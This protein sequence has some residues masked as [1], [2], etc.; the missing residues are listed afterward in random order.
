[1]S[2]QPKHPA[3]EDILHRAAT[4]GD[5]NEPAGWGSFCCTTESLLCAAGEIIVLRVEGE[6]DLCTLPILQAALGES[7]AHHPACLLVDLAGMTFC[8]AWGL[9]L[10]IQTGYTTADKATSFAVRRVS[11]QI[12]RVWTLVGDGDLPIRYRSTEAAMTAVQGRSRLN[13]AVSRQQPDAPPAG[14]MS[15]DAA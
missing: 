7:L 2:G 4:I 1:M 12:D 11:P 9:G 6:I 10:L 3:S 13:T 14:S 8:S 15:P 5:I